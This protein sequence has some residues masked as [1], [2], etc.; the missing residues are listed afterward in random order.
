MTHD[1]MFVDDLQ[2][3]VAGFMERQQ[4]KSK[5]EAEKVTPEQIAGDEALMQ[6]AIERGELRG[7]RKAE[8]KAA[9]ESRKLVKDV[10]EEV[11]A[12]GTQINA[13]E[14]QDSDESK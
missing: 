5:E 11:N 6:E 4:A 8:A 7:D 13:T 1:Q 2:K 9:E 3:A 10:L 14:T 12:F